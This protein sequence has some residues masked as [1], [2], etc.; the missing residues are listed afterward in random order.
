MPYKNP[1]KRRECWRLSQ[2]KHRANQKEKEKVNSSKEA[3]KNN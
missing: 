2:Q 3:N 1:E